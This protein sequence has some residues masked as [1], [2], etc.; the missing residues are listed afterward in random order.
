MKIPAPVVCVLALTTL[1]SFS[2]YVWCM[3]PGEICEKNEYT[4]QKECAKYD[5]LPFLFIKVTKA[6][7]NH[8]GAIGAIATI[9][10]AY[11]T[12]TLYIATDQLKSLAK[13]GG[14]A[15]PKIERA[16]IFVEVRGDLIPI[17]GKQDISKNMSFADIV[18]VNH[19][20][21]PAILSNL[22]SAVWK[23]R[24]QPTKFSTKRGTNIPPGMVIGGTGAHTEQFP[25]GI[26][27]EAEINE[28]L[29]LTINLMIYGTVD[30]VDV[31]GKDRTTNFC[32]QWYPHR[33]DWGIANNHELNCYT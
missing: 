18:I 3:P 6:L 14:E 20:K 1:V 30:Y 4:K 5:A 16:Y 21:T 22:G 24:G 25:L 32:W 27:S 28:I 33:R 29:G 11:F 26:I 15:L 12:F 13:E 17:S 19:G 2:V 23:D 9:F 10:I 31:L 7:D 8:A